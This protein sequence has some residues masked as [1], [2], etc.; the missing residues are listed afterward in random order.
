MMRGTVAREIEDVS[1]EA[2]QAHQ[3]K[4]IATGNP[5]LIE[6]E[7]LGWSWPDWNGPTDPTQHPRRPGEADPGAAS[8]DRRRRAAR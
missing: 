1:D 4:A 3:I 2:L 8:V 5:L 7:E 6:R